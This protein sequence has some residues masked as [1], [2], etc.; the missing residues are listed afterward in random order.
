MSLSPTVIYTY[1]KD[2]PSTRQRETC[3]RGKTLTLLKDLLKNGYVSTGK[4]RYS[5]RALQK[6]FPMIKR[7]Q[8][9]GRSIYYLE[10]GR[11]S[12]RERV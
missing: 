10:I 6:H 7:A 2:I 3:I 5:L 1:T 11:A 4:N 9:K 12:C 8:Y